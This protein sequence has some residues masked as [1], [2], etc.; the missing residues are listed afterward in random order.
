MQFDREQEERFVNVSCFDEYSVSMINRN[1]FLGKMTRFQMR[2]FL[3]KRFS[4]IHRF[5]S[6]QTIRSQ[7]SDV[8][9]IQERGFFCDN[10]APVE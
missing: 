1:E 2:Y 10:I 5:L 9:Q 8:F 6:L 7:S 4:S 3:V